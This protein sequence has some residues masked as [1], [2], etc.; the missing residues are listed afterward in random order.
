LG[1]AG[2]PPRAAPP[3][4]PPTTLRAETNESADDFLARAGQAIGAACES[5]LVWLDW[6]DLYPPWHVPDEILDLYFGAD[7]VGEDGPDPWLD[8]PIGPFDESDLGRLQDSYAA[9]VT[10]FDAQLGALLESVDENWLVVVTAAS[11]L[12]L[13]EHGVIG[14]YR[15]WLHEEVVHLPLLLRFPERAHAGLR[16]AALTQPGDVIAT[17]AELLTSRPPATHGFS[18]LPLIRDEKSD[19]R[20]HALSALQIGDSIE[21]SLRTR[22]WAF[23]LPVQV[24]QGDEPRGAQLYVKPD[25]RWEVNNLYQKHLDLAEEFEK[26]LRTQAGSIIEA[27]TRPGV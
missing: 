25:D 27:G 4:P 14:A 2:A 13:G 21:W 11:G 7:I 18:L 17:I 22:E 23:L 16:I 12:A 1:G 24:P 6:P 8:P 20:Q 10:W 9:A 19:I 5:A 15:A 26:T 3:A